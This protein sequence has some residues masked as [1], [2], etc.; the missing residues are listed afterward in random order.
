MSLYILVEA[1]TGKKGV[2]LQSFSRVSDDIIMITHYVPH[3]CTPPRRFYD[4]YRRYYALFSCFPA[5]KS[6]DYRL[7]FRTC[8]IIVHDSLTIVL[9]HAV[10]KSGERRLI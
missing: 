10:V 8:F 3:Y 5:Q 7:D 6:S 4:E 2:I 1:V 9:A